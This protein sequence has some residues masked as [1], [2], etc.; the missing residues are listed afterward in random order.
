M[1]TATFSAMA[2]RVYIHIADPEIK[3]A[4]QVTSDGREG[5]IECLGWE[6][7]VVNPI[8]PTLG[9]AT[10]QRSYQPMKF[11][12]PLGTHTVPLWKACVQNTFLKTMEVWLY[13]PSNK[14][15]S[16]SYKFMSLKL[17]NAQI[18][19]ITWSVPD[20][21]VLG[22][23]NK[24]G[25]FGGGGG[26][27]FG[28]MGGGMAGQDGRVPCEWVEFTFQDLTMCFSPEDTATEGDGNEHQDCWK[29]RG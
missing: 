27:R 29:A 3:G 23:G 8:N 5:K 15:D 22:E 17:V 16:P 26:S 25:G 9:T 20:S 4:S 2:D 18:C 24:G 28:G 10:G 1:G 13:R 21:E 7:G 6:F 11:R 12:I 14:G 19:A